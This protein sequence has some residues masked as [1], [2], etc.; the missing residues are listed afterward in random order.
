MSELNKTQQTAQSRATSE[1]AAP[2]WERNFLDIYDDL[3]K[4]IP[5]VLI[6]QKKLGGRQID[7]ITW[8][9]A[10]KIMDFYAGG[11]ASEIVRSEI[12]GGKYVVTVRV[13]LRCNDGTVSREATGLESEDYD[14]YGDAASNA[15]AMALKRCFAMFGLGIQMYA[16]K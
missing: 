11:W 14:T 2:T 5:S 10:V 3:R 7:F 16:G 1:R 4:P 6:K 13:T 9:D 8:H 15:S 12:V